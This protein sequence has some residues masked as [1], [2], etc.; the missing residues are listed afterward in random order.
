MSKYQGIDTFCSAQAEDQ[1]FQPFGFAGG[2]YDSDTGLVRFGARDYD[3][4]IGRWTVR[5]PI[6]FGGGTYNVYEYALNDPV[7]GVDPTGLHMLDDPECLAYCIAE[8]FTCGWSLG[9][10]LLIG[11]HLGV[12]HPIS[13]EERCEVLEQAL[14][15]TKELGCGLESWY[16]LRIS[17]LEECVDPKDVYPLPLLF[18]VPEPLISQQVCR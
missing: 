9:S 3:P 8:G 1:A 14:L 13:Q 17:Y 4:E 18:P 10:C 12:A 5:D 7:N 6:L 2:I 16:E 11:C 15:L